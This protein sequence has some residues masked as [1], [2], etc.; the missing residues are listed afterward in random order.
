M[1]NDE[2]ESVLGLGFFRFIDVISSVSKTNWQQKVLISYHFV[3]NYP[4]L[5]LLFYGFH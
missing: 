5:V 3:L 1:I 2:F 4:S